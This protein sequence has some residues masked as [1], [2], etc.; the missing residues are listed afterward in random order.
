M[1][2][3]LRLSMVLAALKEI[4]MS[5]R[6]VSR[7]APC[8]CGSGKKYK[9]CCIRKD[10]DWYEDDEGNIFKSMPISDEMK[11]LL[12]EQRE[13]FVEQ[14]G[15]EP[16]PDDP[17]FPD[18]PHPEHMEHEMVELMKEAGVNPAVIHALEK[19]GR[20]VTEENQ[21]LLTD[22]E[23]DEWNAAIEEYEAEHGSEEPPEFPIGTIALYGPDDETTTKIVAGAI[24]EENA[25]AIIERW[26]GTDVTENPKIRK[27]I[28]E[29]FAKH[30]VTSV[31]ASERNMGCPHEEGEDFPL[32]E[33]CPFC[34]YWKGKQGSNA[35]F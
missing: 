32:G 5:R 24:L 9:Q 19:T 15:R 29:F 2:P 16:G 18:L 10:F 11:E 22:A 6:K 25:E 3:F 14:H 34:P 28:G 31:V 12:D 4:A 35:P 1:I 27:E 21:H 20:L 13:L 23:L 30:G 8:P 26:V 17:V 7:N 33:D